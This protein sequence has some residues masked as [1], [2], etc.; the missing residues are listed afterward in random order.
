MSMETAGSM[1]A[2]AMNYWLAMC[3][4]NAAYYAD[5]PDAQTIW[6]AAQDI[7]DIYHVTEWP[8]LRRYCQDVIEPMMQPSREVVA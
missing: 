8:R 7:I 5:D 2:E 1:E 6:D 3:R 4:L